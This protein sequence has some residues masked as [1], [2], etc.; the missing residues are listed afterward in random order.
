MQYAYDI[1]C[2]FCLFVAVVEII[3]LFVLVYGYKICVSLLLN[4]P[5]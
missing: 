3:N 1:R 4:M 5:V 2:M